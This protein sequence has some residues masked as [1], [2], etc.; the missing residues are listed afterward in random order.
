[1][2]SKFNLSVAVLCTIIIIVACKKNSTTTVPPNMPPPAGTKNLVYVYKND[3]SDGVSFRNLL[4]VNGCSVTLIDRSVAAAFDYSAYDLIVMG[5]NS[6]SLKSAKFTWP[7][8]DALTIRN[9]NKPILL[10]GAGGLLFAEA[11][12]DTVNWGGSAGNIL[13]SF[14]VVDSSLSLYKTPKAISIPA[15][16]QLTIY[17]NPSKLASFYVKSTPVHNVLL[18]G[19]EDD[20]GNSK[21]YPISVD[22]V[23]FVDFGFYA[24]MDAM[25]PTGKDFFVNLVFYTINLGQ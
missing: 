18:M 22:S 23:K 3:S 10:L 25:T 12:G 5:G 8:A 15:N 7:V 6:D 2:K 17:T 11:M 20:I 21:Y 1:M 13:T 24:N 19:E 4:K 14:L 9:T 16:Q